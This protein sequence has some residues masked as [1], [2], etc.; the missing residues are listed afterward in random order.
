MAVL[1]RSTGGFSIK[2][3]TGLVV[4]VAVIAILLIAFPAYRLFF[5]VSVAIGVIV[6]GALF[7]WHK[8]RP[9]REEDVENKKPLGLDR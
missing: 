1:G 7:I 5:A 9:I 2:G 4:A 8:V 6:A 3:K